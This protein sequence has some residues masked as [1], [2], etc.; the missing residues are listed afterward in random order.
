MSY[1]EM[2]SWHANEGLIVWTSV[3]KHYYFYKHLIC[4]IKVLIWHFINCMMISMISCAH[5]TVE[6]LLVLFF[7]SLSPFSQW[8]HHGSSLI[9]QV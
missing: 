7:L 9:I 8:T 2:E 6:S 3:I 4:E 1:V 5:C